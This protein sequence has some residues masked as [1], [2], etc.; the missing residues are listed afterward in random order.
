M[1]KVTNSSF[2]TVVGLRQPRRGNGAAVM[3]LLAA[4]AKLEKQDAQGDALNQTVVL[5]AELY[6]MRLR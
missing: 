2:L 5:G 3:T 1:A 6:L 4:R